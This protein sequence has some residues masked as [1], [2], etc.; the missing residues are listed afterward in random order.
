MYHPASVMFGEKMKGTRRGSVM[1]TAPGGTAGTAVPVVR[2]YWRRFETVGGS[3]RGIYRSVRYTISKT[4]ISNR[5]GK[6][7]TFAILARK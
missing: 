7:L 2:G 4:A 3:G 5:N 1:I 6:K